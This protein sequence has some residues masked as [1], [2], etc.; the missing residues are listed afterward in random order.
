[1]RATVV[2]PEPDSPTR[3][4][5]SPASMLERYIVHY[6][7]QLGAQTRSAGIAFRD[8]IDFNQRH[9]PMVHGPS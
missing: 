5:V 8:C 4:S 9:E 1:M 2:L 6:G 3:P 7:V